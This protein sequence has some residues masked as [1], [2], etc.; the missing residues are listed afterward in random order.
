MLRLIRN[1]L[2]LAML[3]LAAAGMV[4]I[5]TSADPLYS[6][7]ELLAYS[8]YHRYDALIEQVGEKIRR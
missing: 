5:C 3:A 6:T 1:V 7:K 8:R 2:I 4:F